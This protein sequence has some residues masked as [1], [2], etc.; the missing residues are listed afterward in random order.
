MGG[1][2]AMALVAVNVG[3]V[4]MLVLMLKALFQL[5]YKGPIALTAFHCCAAGVAAFFVRSATGL[6]SPTLPLE[7]VG[8]LAVLKVGSLCSSNL[9]LLLNSVTLFEV[10]RFS[11]IPLMCI[12]EYFAFGKR[13]SPAM[14]LALVGIVVGSAI[15]TIGQIE[16]AWSGIVYGMTCTAF[17]VCYQLFNGRLQT[18]QEVNPIQL[19]IYEAPFTTFATISVAAV[20]GETTPVMLFQWTPMAMALA[21]GTGV[22]AVGINISSYC[23]IGRLSPVTYQV[24]GHMK[25][26]C[27][28]VAGFT[29]FNQQL[30]MLNVVGTLIA[31]VAMVAYSRIKDQPGSAESTLATEL[32]DKPDPPA[33]SP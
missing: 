1:A 23:I 32:A 25:T 29:L 13:Y 8:M 9:S 10:L 18:I 16:F 21:L 31:V 17:T 26:A 4:V 14:Y 20:A 22:L 12:V 27:I 7:K 30:S 24:V 15:A 33:E 2:T 28:L 5:G 3:C 11:T 19:L 6:S